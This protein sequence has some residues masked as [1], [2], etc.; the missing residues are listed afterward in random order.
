MQE[1]R[2]I[3]NG[4]PKR[5]PSGRLPAVRTK[6]VGGLVENYGVGVAEVARQSGNLDLWGFEDPD[7]NFVQLVN[8][9]PSP[10][11]SWL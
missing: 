3:A 2:S 6:I 11:S 7:E 4:T 1:E 9:V 5:E 10:P 8:S